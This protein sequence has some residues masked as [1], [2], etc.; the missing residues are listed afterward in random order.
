MSDLVRCPAEFSGVTWIEPDACH[1]TYTSPF[2]AASVSMRVHWGSSLYP[3]WRYAVE[4]ER[5]SVVVARSAEREPEGADVV[6]EEAVDVDLV[7]EADLAVGEADSVTA[8]AG[9]DAVFAAERFSGSCWAT[10]TTL[11]GL[12][13]CGAASATVPP[14]SVPATV[15]AATINGGRRR[16]PPERAA[17]PSL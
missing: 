4:V 10:D 7:V 2:G 13:Q 1:A 14:I 12:F 16:R 3:D 9:A 8:D 5:E 17:F 6:L 15:R 11:W